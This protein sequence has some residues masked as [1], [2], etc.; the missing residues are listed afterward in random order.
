[1]ARRASPKVRNPA[2]EVL[3]E[4][5]ALFRHL[6]HPRRLTKNALAARIWVAA[7]LGPETADEAQ[8]TGCLQTALQRL[9]HGLLPAQRLIV[10][11]CD[12]EGER[13]IDVASQLHISVRHLYRQRASAFSAIARQFEAAEVL[14]SAR[15][16]P[17][18]LDALE[19]QLRLARGLEQNGQW[20]TAAEILE[21][22]CHDVSDVAP[23]PRD[24]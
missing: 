20:A 15:L 14:F 16:P 13:N 17:A 2:P 9:L 22:L 1:M 7:G 23:R 24:R 11:R 3:R 8:L 4:C 18:A 5:R 21:R 19:L 6:A 10:E 12:L